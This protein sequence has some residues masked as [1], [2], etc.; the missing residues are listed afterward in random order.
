MVSEGHRPRPQERASHNNVGLAHSQKQDYSRAIEWYGK[1]IALDPKYAR[2][3]NNLGDSYYS[4]KR[5]DEAIGSYRKAADLEPRNAGIL[6]TLGVAYRERKDYD[7]SIESFRKLLLIQP[8]R[9]DAHVNIVHAYHLKGQHDQAIEWNHKAV[10]LEPRNA[11]ARHLLILILSTDDRRPPPSKPWRRPA[12][13][14]RRP[15]GRNSGITPPAP[16]PWPDAQTG[17]PTKLPPAERCRLRK[18]ALAW[19][20]EERGDWAALAKSADPAVRKAAAENCRQVLAADE[21]KGVRDPEAVEKLEA[22]ERKTWRDFWKAIQTLLTE[23]ES[24][25]AKGA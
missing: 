17:D 23:L 7:R 18:Q 3:Y 14:S 21:F 25:P 20:G 15:T 13:P 19:L 6:Y 24:P 10:A 8:E 9:M 12:A 1:A 4:Q 11:D 22:E 16:T 2:A 5:F